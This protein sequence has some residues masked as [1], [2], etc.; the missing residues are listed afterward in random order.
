M[1]MAF[2]FYFRTKEMF[3]AKVVEGQNRYAGS[4]AQVTRSVQQVQQSCITL[5]N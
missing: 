2:L 1:E 4:I 3:S 5:G